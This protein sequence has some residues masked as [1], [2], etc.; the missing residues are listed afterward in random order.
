VSVTRR[1]SDAPAAVARPDS[2]IL[3]IGAAPEPGD[4]LERELG[5]HGIGTELIP[6]A[7]RGVNAVRDGRHRLILLDLDLGFADGDGFDVLTHLRRVRPHLPVIAL[8][9]L[10]GSAHRIR[11]LDTGAVDS[12]VMPFS[13]PELVARI[14]A[15]LRQSDATR[16]TLGAA[17]IDV[18]LVTRTVVHHGVSVHLSPMEF[19]LL[20]H[21]M[22]HAGTTQSRQDILDSV[23]AHESEAGRNLVD[24]YI[25]YLRRKLNADRPGHE[26]PIQTVR[27]RG[28]R[29]VAEEAVQ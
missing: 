4:A 25:G 11:A 13:L 15:Q 20:V 19:R 9:A 14:R 1:R 23:W 18:D 3:I 10:G 24:V 27:S 7:E 5:C 6:D 26:S 12:V 16:T 22:Q 8:T 2:S 17:G 21:L 29:F 28:Y